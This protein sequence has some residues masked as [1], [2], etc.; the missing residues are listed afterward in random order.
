MIA[1]GESQCRGVLDYIASR[2]KACLHGDQ[3]ILTRQ[4]YGLK[5]RCGFPIRTISYWKCE[6]VQ[7]PGV[8]LTVLITYNKSNSS[9]SRSARNRI[10]TAIG[11]NWIGRWCHFLKTSRAVKES[12]WLKE[13]VWRKVASSP[14]GTVRRSLHPLGKIW[15]VRF[16]INPPRPGKRITIGVVRCGLAGD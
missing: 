15:A 3:S 14:D 9:R 7:F 11:M 5:D 1:R 12:S 6:V 8:A 4:A 13:D 10:D 16:T 2:R